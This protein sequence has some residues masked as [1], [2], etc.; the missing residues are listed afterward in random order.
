MGS[1][2]KLFYLELGMKQ[3]LIFKMWV[4]LL[5]LYLKPQAQE[6]AEKKEAKQISVYIMA[7]QSNMMGVSV[8]DNLDKL[9]IELQKPYAQVLCAEYWNTALTPLVPK[10][11][12][13]PEFGFG[14]EIATFTGEPIGIIKLAEGG[15]SLKQH[16]NP[17]A[18]LYNKEKGIGVFYKRLIDYVASMKKENPNIK[19]K[20]MCWRLI[21]N[22]KNS[23]S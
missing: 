11:H 17:D 14:K 15:T 3:K 7:G 2:Q 22:Q 6:K 20:G 5:L 13:G 19:I 23:K 1:S 4:I 18:N 10:N 9:P 8:K 16:W 21:R 12:I